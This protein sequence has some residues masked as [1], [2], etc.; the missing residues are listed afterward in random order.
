MAIDVSSSLPPPVTSSLTTGP[1]VHFGFQL[2]PNKIY[3]TFL[4]TMYTPV[5][6]MRS[7]NSS[8]LY[9]ANDDAIRE[10]ERE[11]KGCIQKVRDGRWRK[12]AAEHEWA[13]SPW[14]W[15]KDA[16][17]KSSALL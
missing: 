4:S 6:S 3:Q 15:Q 14:S 11:V 5:A 17:W 13:L 1:A 10:R 12:E 7:L 16:T 2:K 8:V 9:T